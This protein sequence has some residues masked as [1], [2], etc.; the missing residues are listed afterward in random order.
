MDR[1]EAL[2]ISFANLK[3][4]RDKQ[5]IQTAKALDHLKSL[6]E[7]GSNAAVGRAVGVSG[8]IVRE[9]VSLL[10][11]PDEV[12]GLLES[13]ELGLEQ[14]RRLVQLERVRPSVLREAAQ[15]MVGLLSKDSRNLVEY[16]CNYRDV[17]VSEARERILGSKTVRRREF[18]LVARL[19]EQDYRQLKAW[20]SR[21]RQPVDELV[22]EIVTAWLA[23]RKNDA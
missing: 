19:P 11:L 20:A 7:Y 13:G 2:A 1:Q 4:P 10:Q 12:Q 3:G 5:L 18:H 16:L 17:S 6:P 15:A 14:G 9:F 8:E 22:T 21:R 23:Q